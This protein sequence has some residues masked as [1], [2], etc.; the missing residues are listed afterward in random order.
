MDIKE[1]LERSGIKELNPVQKKAVEKGFG[2]NMIVA[3]PTASGKT[4]IAEIAALKTI[5]EGKKVVYIV[6]L[7]A[8]AQEKYEDFKRKYE[9][10]G[11]KVGIS[12]GDLDSSDSWLARFDLIIVTSEKLDSLLRH[13]IGWA[14]SI[15]LVIA[16]EIHLLTDPGRGPTLEIVLTRLREFNPLIL[17]LS[18]TISNHEELAAWLRAEAVHSDY[19]PVKLF[20]GVCFDNEVTLVPHRRYDVASEN[21]LEELTAIGKQSLVFI[22]TRKGTEASAE[23]LAK[24]FSLKLSKKE[25]EDLGHISQ[26][27]LSSLEHKTQ[28]CERLA[29]CVQNGTAFHHAGLANTQRSLVEENFKKG[30]IKVICATPTLAAGLNLPA[31]RVIIRDLKRFSSYRGMDFIPVLEAQQMMGRAGRPAYDTEGEAILLP[32]N[33]GEADYCWKNYIH[34]ESEKI[35][36]K[37]GVEPVLRTHVLALIAGGVTPTKKE[38]VDFFGKTFYAFQYKD[39][40][41]IK[42]HLDKVLGLLEKWNFIKISGQEDGHFKQAFYWEEDSSSLE[43]TLLGKRVAELY[44]DPLTAEFLVRTLK[45][46]DAPI[47]F[48]VLHLIASCLEMR[49]GLSIRKKDIIDISATVAD[50]EKFLAVKPPNEWDI[51]YE[52]YLKGVKMALML[53]TWCEEKGEDYLLETFGVTPGELRARLDIADWLLYATQ[54]IALLLGQMDILKDI[55]KSRLRLRYG[56]KQELLPL[57]RLKGVGRVRARKLFDSGVKNLGDLR[58]IPLESLA[59]I[60][61]MAVAESIKNQLGETEERGTEDQ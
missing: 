50:E 6:P 30:L 61:G 60:A 5:G 13:G 52:D 9:P 41:Q 38:L 3:A 14:S 48:T 21:T 56:I 7:R 16:D 57:V 24:N 25:R 33:K 51:D 45:G 43:P 58:K 44:I 15:G 18:A 2:R 37:L 10:L 26:K 23:R 54:E 8:L 19:R 53:G 4:L 42:N 31:Y 35:V 12:I 1:I 46:L 55:R 40:S 27:I 20:K 29:R 47:L 34:G 22:S 49:P 11:L 32:K 39:M 28:Q 17:G 36:S 59:R